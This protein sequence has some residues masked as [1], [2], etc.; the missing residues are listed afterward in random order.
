MFLAGTS[1]G[2]SAI[3]Q[4][5]DNG[6]H[7][8][9]R[10]ALDPDTVTTFNIDAWAVADDSALFA[11]SFDGSNGLVYHT[12]N[13]GWTYSTGAV[14][15]SQSLNSIV[16]SPDYEQDETILAG[17]TNGWVYWSSDNGISFEPL[18]PEATSPSLTGSITVVFDP[19]FSRNRTVYAASNTPDKG[20][21]RVTI[22]KSTKTESIAGTLPPG[23]QVSPPAAAAD[24]TLYATNFQ[25]D[26]GM[27]R[28]LNPTYSLGPKFET[29]TRG[30]D[31]GATLTGL[32]LG[33]RKLWSIDS[34]NTSLMTCIDT[35]TVPVDWSSPSS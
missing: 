10:T 16:L 29:V 5:K 32:W 18:P 9:R 23:G 20:V 25:A 11:G 26:G 1:N 31:D 35:R 6:Q 19:E 17:N 2:K 12:T 13:S 7:F 21:Y 34:H 22:D 33:G 30:L 15:G 27:E 4:S 24:G 14:A 8:T 28:S 3:W